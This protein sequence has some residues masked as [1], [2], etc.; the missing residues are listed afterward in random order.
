MPKPPSLPT[1][2]HDHFRKANILHTY[3]QENLG[4]ATKH[5]LGTGQELLEA[6]KVVAH[7]NWEESCDRMFD[8]SIRTAQSY[9]AFA[10]DFAKLK[11]AQKPALLMLESTLEG[12]AKAARKIVRPEK[13]HQEPPPESSETTPPLSGDEGEDGRTDADG[14][15]P[16][17]TAPKPPRKGR[18]K[19]GGSPPKRLDRNAFYKQWDNAIGPLV[20]LVD[21]IAEGVGESR[22]GHHKDVQEH[23]NDAT[24]CMREW[25]QVEK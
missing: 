18:A 1:E 14:T 17:E 12:A 2:V 11:S 9:M 20:R 23:L 5:A 6:K 10:K 15:E 4:E 24:E 13:L 16:Q 8:G 3:V 19:R 25:M 21:K 22:N 7:G